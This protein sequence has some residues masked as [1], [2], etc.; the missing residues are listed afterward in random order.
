MKAES[1]LMGKEAGQ[2]G[3]TPAR[4]VVG[5]EPD[6]ECGEQWFEKLF[7]SLKRS[8]ISSAEWEGREAEATA[9]FQ[10]QWVG[11]ATT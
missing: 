6:A 5:Q 10:A 1:S 7:Q 8:P 4:K 2:S 3:G 9:T 11:C